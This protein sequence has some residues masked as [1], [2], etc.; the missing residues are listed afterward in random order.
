MTHQPF[1]WF[2]MHSARIFFASVSISV[3]CAGLSLESSAIAAERPDKKVVFNPP[4][5][6]APT[7]TRGGASRGNLTCATVEPGRTRQVSLFVPNQSNFGWTVSERPV[8]FAY[9]PP[10]TAS[11]VL[12]SLKNQADELHYK[13]NVPISSQGGV[14]AFALPQ[15]TKPL[16]LGERYQWSVTVLCNG[17]LRPD[18][19]YAIGWVQR[20]TMPAYSAAQ[21]LFAQTGSVQT[22]A[23]QTQSVPALS[24]EQAA[25][26]G[27]KGVWYDMLTTLAELR[28]QQPKDQVLA[29]TWSKLLESVGL[30]AI[31]QE[32]LL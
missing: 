5:G 12:F 18:S 2:K 21:K 3:V 20:I 23:V 29:T 19:P 26:Y 9:V 25:I 32:P 11:T 1:L 8:F 28:R 30:T 24:L 17:K 4:G 31:A 15:S 6:G 27:E 22:R 10:T 7:E 16:A 13:T 14:V